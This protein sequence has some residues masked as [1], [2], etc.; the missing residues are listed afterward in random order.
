M[1]TAVALMCAIGFAS[2]DV[3]L[4]QDTKTVVIQTKGPPKVGDN[5]VQVQITDED[6]KPI[7]KAV[8]NLLVEMTEMDMGTSKVATVGQGNGLYEATIKFSMAGKWKVTAIVAAD[9]RPEMKKSSEFL[10]KAGAVEGEP[11]IAP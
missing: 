3:T 5:Q 8:V 7:D 10:V 1:G 4:P 2:D 6:N 9:S 11:T